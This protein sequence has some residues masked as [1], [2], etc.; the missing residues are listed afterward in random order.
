MCDAGCDGLH[1]ERQP[2]DAPDH[3]LAFRVGLGGSSHTPPTRTAEG[4]RNTPVSSIPH[5]ADSSLP[6]LER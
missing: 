1:A 6:V 5:Q 4:H 2:E 3:R